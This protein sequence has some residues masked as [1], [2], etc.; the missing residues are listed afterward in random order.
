MTTG[1]S[2]LQRR[3]AAI[4]FG[5]IL[6]NYRNATAIHRPYLRLL[7]N[8]ESRPNHRNGQK[9]LAQSETN[10]QRDLIERMFCRLV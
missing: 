5:S 4:G 2:S 7:R 10:R 3:S 1:A 6:P 9:S 8:P